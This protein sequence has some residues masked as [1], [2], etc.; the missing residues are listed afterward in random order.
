M[1]II[2]IKDEMGFPC[3]MCYIRGGGYDP[4]HKGCQRCE[5]NVLAQL[6]KSVLKTHHMC[7]FCRNRNNLG[8][9][10]WNCKITGKDDG[11]CKLEDFH[12]DC[13]A[14]AKEYGFKQIDGNGLYEK[15]FI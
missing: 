13:E 1:K 8:G 4:N 5:N 9:G 7:T 3:M 15:E 10:Y 14:V 11:C 2:P 6:L 12:I